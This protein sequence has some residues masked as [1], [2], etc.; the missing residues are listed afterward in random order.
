VEGQDIRALIQDFVV[1]W[2]T[3]FAEVCDR[4]ASQI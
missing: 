3:K 1:R 4:E 2:Y